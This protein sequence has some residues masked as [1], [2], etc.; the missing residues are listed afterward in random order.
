MA[1][2]A[3][4]RDIEGQTD[5]LPSTTQAAEA[6]KDYA[7]EWA[8]RIRQSPGRIILAALGLGYVAG[9]IFR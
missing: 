1:D 9:R 8:E 3:S 6:A 4:A 7:A 2:N 5:Q